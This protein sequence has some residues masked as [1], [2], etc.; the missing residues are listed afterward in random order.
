MANA[1]P[2]RIGQVNQANDVDALFLK[3]FS[4]EV[5]S[6]FETAT[7]TEGLHMQRT[8]SSGKSSQFPVTGKVGAAYHTPG[9]ELVGQGTNQAERIITIDDLL[10]SDVF[11]ADI[12]EA[13]NHFDYRSPLSTE[14]GRKLGYAKD[15]AVFKEIV[16]AARATASVQDGFGGSEIISDK[17]RITGTGSSADVTELAAALATGLFSAA[18][19]LDEKDVPD[20][21]RYAC[22]K[23]AEYY[24]LAQ[25]T[26][27]I[28]KDWGGAGAYADGSILRIAGIQI[29]K[30]N[31]LPKT[32][33]T[34]TDSF[35]G[36]DATKT[37]GLVWTPDAVGTVKLLDLSMQNQYDVRR[38]GTLLVARYAMGHGVLR[39]DCAIE[40]KLDDLV[41]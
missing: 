19:Q 7:I 29:L 26:D 30:S 25:N 21:N 2:A 32:D 3:V 20:M 6:A 17:F 5:L 4:G 35:H 12:D 8:I 27:L 38:Q 22:F 31:H 24:A 40:L 10:V 18:Q 15:N 9:T 11:I 34:G 28:N 13:K 41:N 39:P 14:M 33:T 1:T 36:V 37:R 16:K 23:P